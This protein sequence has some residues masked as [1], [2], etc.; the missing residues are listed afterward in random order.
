MGRRAWIVVGF[1]CL[2]LL[3]LVGCGG[4]ESSLPP[5]RADFSLIVSPL[6]L[7]VQQGATSEAASLSVNPQN[8]F[9][10]SVS[11]AIEGLPPGGTSS[12]ASPFLV[13]AKSTRNVTFT[14]PASVTPADYTLSLKATSGSLSH[15]VSFKLTVTPHP[16]FSLS[17]DPTSVTVLLGLTSEPVV[18]S[19]ASISGF[20]G[21]VRVELLGLPPGLT[22]SPSSPFNVDAGASQP[23]TLS[24]STSVPARPYGL[25]VRGTSGELVHDVKL[26]ADVRPPFPVPAQFVAKQFTEALGRLPS[27]AEWRTWLDYY[28]TEGCNLRTLE[29]AGSIYL[30]TEYSSLGLDNAAKLLTL[31]RGVLNREPDEVGYSGFLAALDN[32]QSWDTMVDSFFGSAEFAGLVDRICSGEPYYFGP[33][34]AIAIPVSGEGFQGGTGED[35]QA[36]LDQAPAG[37][38]VWLAQKSLTRLSAPLIIPTGVTLAT[39]GN[40]SPSRYAMMGR[41][42]RTARYDYGV[43]ALQ[44]GATLASVWVDGQRG[45]I[46]GKGPWLINMV[47]EG[48]TDTRVINSVSSNTAGWSSL[49]ARGATGAPCQGNEVSGNLITAYSSDHYDRLWSDGLSIECQ[50]A[51]VENNQIVDASDAAIVVFQGGAVTQRSIVRNN[52]ILSAGNSAYGALIFDPVFPV[53][54]SATNPDF[55]GSS[56]TQ[57]TLWTGPYTHFDIAISVGTMAWYYNADG[58]IGSGGQAV[59]NTSGQEVIRGNTGI[60]VDGMLNTTVEGNTLQMELVPVSDCPSVEV[61]ADVENGHASGVIQPY[62]QAVFHSCIAHH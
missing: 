45:A 20:S 11:V 23:M 52:V 33:N 3:I 24:A 53:E 37:T 8:G 12:P 51:L 44:P 9:S 43:V 31:Y 59:E 62:V 29:S 6:S 34:P 14:I 54:W 1:A 39:I 48:G 32:G 5:P 49:Y 28:E 7:S 50:D 21:S 19:A 30:G 4:G 25:T 40:P 26:D 38:T 10:G 27:Q 35:L 42:V 46:G 55:T 15:Q 56:F 58:L 13:D 17:V 2:S 47:V 22:S 41:L 18:V 16:D 36:L 57:N 60:A 61:G